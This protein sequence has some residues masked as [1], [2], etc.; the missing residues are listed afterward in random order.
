MTVFTR[1]HVPNKK[2]RLPEA[3]RLL[4]VTHLHFSVYHAVIKEKSEGSQN[5]LWRSKECVR[6]SEKYQCTPNLTGILGEFSGIEN[7]FTDPI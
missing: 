6:I 4:S 1:G 5:T 7:G 3:P 2:R